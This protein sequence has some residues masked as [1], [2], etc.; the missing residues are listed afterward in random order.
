MAFTGNEDHQI[1]LTDASRY[2]E[3]FRDTI[4]PSD[5]DQT[6]GEYFSKAYLLQL[7]GQ[8][9]CVGVRVYYGLNDDG[10]RA[11]VI[12]GV[13]ANQ[14]DLYNGTLAEHGL[15]VPPW[16]GTANPLNS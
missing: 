8:A 4:D 9:N 11:L 12:S 13:K 10:K 5:P 14:D 15:T 2:T 3:N 7:L 6:I 16:S 1:D